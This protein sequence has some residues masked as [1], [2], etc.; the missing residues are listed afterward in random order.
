MRKSGEIVCVREKYDGSTLSFYMIQQG[1]SFVKEKIKFPCKYYDLK[2]LFVQIMWREYLAI[3]CRECR[4]IKLLD[5]ETKELTTAYSDEQEMRNMSKGWHKI[6]VEVP[7]GYLELDCTSMDFTK[8]RQIETQRSGMKRCLD[9]CYIPPPHSLIVAVNHSGDQIFDA[10]SLDEPN[11][12]AWH[13]TLS[14]KEDRNI[15]IIYS[16]RHDAL[17]VTDDKNRTI[18]VLNPE[19][20]DILQTIHVADIDYDWN[21]FIFGNQLVIVSRD[22]SF[23]TIIKYFSFN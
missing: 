1:G 3:S 17:L 21:V 22:S 2:M 23:N 6:Y 10:T 11:R 4:D 8:I 15:G 16:K 14:G 19:S 12:T 9:M 7:S 13:L 20:G 18:R 5:L